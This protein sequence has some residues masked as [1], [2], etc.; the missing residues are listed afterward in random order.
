MNAIAVNKY[1]RSKRQQ[2]PVIVTST[3]HSWSFF[4]S[5]TSEITT[6]LASSDCTCP[7]VRGDGTTVLEELC[8][9]DEAIL[10]TEA[11]APEF[12]EASVAVRK[13]TVVS[14]NSPSHMTLSW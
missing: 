5:I 10:E 2:L 1:K 6:G 14:C 13:V 4:S 7:S 12:F 3:M 11:D 9:T 8:S